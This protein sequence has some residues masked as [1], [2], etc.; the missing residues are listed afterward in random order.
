MNFDDRWMP[1]KRAWPVIVILTGWVLLTGAGGGPRDLALIGSWAGDLPVDR[2]DLLP[3]D[4]RR[5]PVGFIGDPAVFE[6]VWKAVKPGDRIPH[7]DFGENMVLFSRNVDFYNRTSILKVTLEAG[8]ARIIAMQTMSAMFIEDR[9]AM[10]M[11]VVPRK[12]IEFIIA[13]DARIRVADHR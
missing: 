10:A 5:T 8:Q 6:A 3:E 13:G 4:Q 7:V 2:L 12:G 11:A 9:V 1:A